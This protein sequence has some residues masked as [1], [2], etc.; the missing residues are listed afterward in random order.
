MGI[1]YSAALGLIWLIPYESNSQTRIM[2]LHREFTEFPGEVFCGKRWHDPED[3]EICE[4]GELED[5]SQEKTHPDH[6]TYIEEYYL[7]PKL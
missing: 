2:F 3:R 4:Y 7:A 1:L 5:T 6:N